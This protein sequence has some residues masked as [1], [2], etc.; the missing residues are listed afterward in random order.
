METH[1]RF[2]LGSSCRSDTH[3]DRV[4]FHDHDD[5]EEEHSAQ[6]HCDAGDDEGKQLQRQH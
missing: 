6:A 3:N 4:A 1:Q 5:D 2:R